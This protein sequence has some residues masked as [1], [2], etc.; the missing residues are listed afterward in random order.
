M[1]GADGTDEARV[2]LAPIAGVIEIT[3]REGLLHVTVED[4]ELVRS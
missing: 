4:L 1:I 3:E 2:L